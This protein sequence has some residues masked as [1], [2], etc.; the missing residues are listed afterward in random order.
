M[1]A[2]LINLSVLLITME[3]ILKLLNLLQKDCNV[4]SL[5]IFR[6]IA[7]GSYHNLFNVYDRSGK[8]EATLEAT[9]I[10]SKVKK[11]VKMKTAKKKTKDELNPDA[12]DLSR[13]ILHL[14]WHP[15]E[16][17]LAAGANNNIFLFNA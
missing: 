8:N 12:L 11:P 10:A 15:H 17:L 4:F 3:R 9:K 1:I 2:F 13:K 16:N 6:L 5:I 14:A 7:T